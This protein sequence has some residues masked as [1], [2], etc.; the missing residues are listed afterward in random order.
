MWRRRPLFDAQ[1]ILRDRHAHSQLTQAVKA[2]WVSPFAPLAHARLV[3]CG[4]EVSLFCGPPPLTW[5]RG[6][7]CSRTD[8]PA[9]SLAAS[10]ALADRR[11]IGEMSCS[12]FG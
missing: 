2:T 12:E 5:I 1:C 10:A 3:P 9:P 7:S 4:S 6:S 8:L 11:G